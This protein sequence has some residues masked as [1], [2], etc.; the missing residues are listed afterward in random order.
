MKNGKEAEKNCT[1]IDRESSR[2]WNA[3]PRWACSDCVACTSTFDK[4]RN[5][6]TLCTSAVITLTPERISEIAPQLERYLAWLLQ[7]NPTYDP[8][9]AFF[10]YQTKVSGVISHFENLRLEA[11]AKKSWLTPEDYL[12]AACKRPQLFYQ[13][14]ERIAGNI[15]GV[16]EKFKGQGLTLEAYLA[17]ARKQPALFYQKPERII[18]NITGVVEK[19]KNQGLTLEAYL[20]VACKKPQLFCQKPE[21]I[22]GNITAVVEKFKDQGLT[23]EVYL[24]VA[25]KRP[26]LFCQKPETIINHINILFGLY[27]KGIFALPKQYAPPEGKTAKDYPQGLINWLMTNSGI[28]ILGSDNLDLRSY[29]AAIGGKKPSAAIVQYTRHKAEQEIREQ[30]GHPDKKATAP[31]FV[32]KATGER[33]FTAGDKVPEEK[34]R[35]AREEFEKDA[36]TFVLRALMR[37]GY[38]KGEWER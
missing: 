3:N 25:C 27:E 31:S 22:A 9:E 8:K 14:P 33:R 15:T 2:L 23:L 37:V 16:V 5:Y 21:T 32:D 4:I 28:I 1:R 36:K 12:T 18:G 24:A 6:R 30:L 38:V 17:A 20:A 7:K 35:V 13:K 34:G 29:Y 19:F 10:D 26:P 11:K